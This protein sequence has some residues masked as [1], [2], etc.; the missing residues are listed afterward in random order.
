MLHQDITDRIIGAFYSVYN[1]LG[2]G[3]LEKVY[4]NALTVELGNRGLHV[5]R[6]APIKVYYAE[7]LVGE[8]FAD[9]LI[10]STVIAELKAVEMI[11]PQHKAQ[12]LNYLKA[13]EIEVGLLLNF[14]PK[15]EVARQLFTNDRKKSKLY[16]PT[17]PSLSVSSL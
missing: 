14:G 6:Q 4:E 16:L 15:P 17:D 5:L 2:Y 7:Q 13:T 10:E 11:H 8:Y 1:T 3:F 9:L 12:L